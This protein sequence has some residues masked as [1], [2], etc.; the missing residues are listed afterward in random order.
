M[1]VIIYQVS[2]YK[3]KK[4]LIK[5]KESLIGQK[6]NAANFDM[7]NYQ[8]S[9]IEFTFDELKLKNHKKILSYLLDNFESFYAFDGRDTVKFTPSDL[10]KIGEYLY[11]YNGDKEWIS[12]GL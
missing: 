12:L 10:V 11:Y 9:H 7:K 6:Y 4:Y 2:E 8:I 3:N 5:H 1:R